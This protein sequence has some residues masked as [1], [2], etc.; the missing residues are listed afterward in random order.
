MRDLEK[1][2]SKPMMPHS[3]GHT[4]GG[5]LRSYIVGTISRVIFLLIFLA[6]MAY[7]IWYTHRPVDIPT[8]SFETNRA[9]TSRE[10]LS[11]QAAQAQKELETT[12]DEE[13]TALDLVTCR[14]KD[15]N[16]PLTYWNRELIRK[17][18]KLITHGQTSRDISVLMKTLGMCYDDNREVID[19]LP[20][21]MKSW[22][23]A[24][25]C[26]EDPTS[27]EVQTILNI[28]CKFQVDTNYPLRAQ[29]QEEIRKR[30]PLIVYR[31]S[32]KEADSLLTLVGFWRDEQGE[33]VRIEETPVDEESVETAK[34]LETMNEMAQA[35]AAREK[36]RLEKQAEAKRRRNLDRQNRRDIKSSVNEVLEDII[37]GEEAVPEEELSEEEEV[38]PEE[39]SAEEAELSEEEE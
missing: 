28:L 25:E 11:Q 10:V 8:S 6:V 39:E 38:V 17:H 35:D 23:E 12:E 3:T 26:P 36:I 14:Q 18:W 27:E 1:Y 7:A 2:D 24:G 37:E 32:P 30:W 5:N 15:V 16:F 22:D 9:I 20:K 21:G 34:A 29:D 31:M 13:Q 19:M 33:L 4:A